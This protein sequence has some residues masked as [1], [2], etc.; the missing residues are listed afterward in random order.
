MF[1]P[2][3]KPR[4]ILRSYG[5]E[6]TIF[7]NSRQWDSLYSLFSRLPGTRQ[8]I[9]A[10][11]ERVQTSCAFAVPLY[12]YQGQRET[13]VNWVNT[14]GEQGVKEYHQQKNFVSIEGLLTTLFKVQNQKFIDS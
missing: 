14:K 2:F 1:C 10:D 5:K 11:I 7:P 8:I 12:E 6:K 9:V 4:S 13:L 3:Q